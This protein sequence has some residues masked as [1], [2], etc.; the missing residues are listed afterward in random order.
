MMR[1]V[2]LTPDNFRSYT[3]YKVINFSEL[4]DYSGLALYDA[5][6]AGVGILE[7]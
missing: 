3:R 6:A 7:R 5:L 2:S 4:K 1:Q